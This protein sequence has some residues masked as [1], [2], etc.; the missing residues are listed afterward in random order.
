MRARG[1]QSI[2]VPIRLRLEFEHLT[3]AELSN[4]LSNYQRMLRASWRETLHDWQAQHS[5]N[6]RLVVSGASSGSSPVDIWTD[7]IIP[8][9]H[10]GSALVGPLKDWPSVVKT[11]FHYLRVLWSVA[12]EQSS[13]DSPDRVNITG[14]SNPQLNILVSVLRDR[15]TAQEIK[16]LWDI[17]Q[18]GRIRLTVTLNDTG[19]SVS[20]EPEGFQRAP[21]KDQR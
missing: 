10:L 11:I 8:G 13:D 17:A 1:Y 12:D 18:R 21:E 6:V 2:N 16:E 14:G 15:R 4:I 19:E 7:Y 20:F 9:I 3:V 5:P